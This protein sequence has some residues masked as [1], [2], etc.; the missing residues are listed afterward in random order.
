[1]LLSF[2]ITRAHNF[3]QHFGTTEVRH[4]IV[5]HTSVAGPEAG[6]VEKIAHFDSLS[7]IPGPVIVENAAKLLFPLPIVSSVPTFRILQHFK[8]GPSRSGP[9]DPLL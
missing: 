5:R 3:G 6:D 1:M 7:A 2:P 9:S 8:L 4:N